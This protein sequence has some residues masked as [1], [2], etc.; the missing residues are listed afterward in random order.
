M[1]LPELNR[2]AEEANTRIIP[3][4]NKISLNQNACAFVL[5]NDTDVCVL[6][7]HY[8]YA[9][10]NNGLSEFWTRYGTGND[11]QSIPIH[12]LYVHVHIPKALSYLKLTL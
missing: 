7:L 6:L 11:Q 3:H 9:F 12:A 10:Q 8:M 4:L 5:S 1:D 2:D